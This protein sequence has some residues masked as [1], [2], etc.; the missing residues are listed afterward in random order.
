MAT[1]CKGGRTIEG[2]NQMNRFYSC[3][4]KN[5]GVIGLQG[6]KTTKNSMASENE[7]IKKPV[8]IQCLLSPYKQGC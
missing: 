2:F 7:K 5:T 6:L 4:G 1:Y 3:W 8:S